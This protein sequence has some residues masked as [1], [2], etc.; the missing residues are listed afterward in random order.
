MTW[1]TSLTIFMEALLKDL[2]GFRFS[3]KWISKSEALFLGW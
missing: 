2:I 1:D 3:A